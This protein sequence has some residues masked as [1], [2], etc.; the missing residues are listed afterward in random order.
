MIASSLFVLQGAQERVGA[1]DRV[2]ETGRDPLERR[3]DGTYEWG[4]LRLEGTGWGG[5]R[6]DLKRTTRWQDDVIG[7]VGGRWDD[8][9]DFGAAPGE[10]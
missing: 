7:V 4:R 9:I 6:A 5:A 2:V 8:Q 1:A 10:G 3:A